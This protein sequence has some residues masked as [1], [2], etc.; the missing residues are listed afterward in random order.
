MR[1]I[2]NPSCPRKFDFEEYIKGFLLQE[3]L[4]FADLLSAQTI[5]QIFQRFTQPLCG[6]Y[7]HAL[8]LWAFLSQVLRD[9]KEAS[10]QSAVARIIAHLGRQW[11]TPLPQPTPAT[12]V[13][14]VPSY[15]RQHFKN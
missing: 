10:C 3:G 11:S 15:L 9:G 14:L 1:S 5:A 4:P 2:P 13:E 12:I 7:T 6:I 8:V